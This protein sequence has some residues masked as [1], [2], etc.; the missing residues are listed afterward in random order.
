MGYSPK[1]RPLH[2]ISLLRCLQQNHKYLFELLRVRVIVHSKF[3]LSSLK[4]RLGMGYWTGLLN[5]FDTLLLVGV[6]LHV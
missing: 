3:F 2:S 4:D 1:Y 6:V 5:P